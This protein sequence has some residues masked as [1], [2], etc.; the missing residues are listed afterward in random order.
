MFLDK[1][2]VGNSLESLEFVEQE[3]AILIR[4]DNQSPQIFSKQKEI[5]HKRLF[6]LGL[7]GKDIYHND[8]NSIRINN[9]FIKINCRTNNYKYEF[10]E[11]HV[12]DYENL[13]IEDNQLIEH[14]TDVYSVVDWL[15]VKQGVDFSDVDS[16]KID[17]SFIEEII[18][19]ES[20]RVDHNPSFKDIVVKSKISKNLIND[21]ECCLTMV[22]FYCEQY[23]SDEY[24]QPIKLESTKRE[25]RFLNKPKYKNSKKI[26]FYD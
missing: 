18:F 23:L 21:F 12:F 13:M 19:Y 14:K 3:G 2:V 25:K 10:S 15:E 17:D 20:N 22:K 4:N 7:A 6:H 24:A 26:K 11:C 8:I 5:W 1:V 9:E 16:I